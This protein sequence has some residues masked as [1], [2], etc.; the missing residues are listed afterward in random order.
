MAKLKSGTRVYGDATVDSK[1]IVTNGNVGVGTTNPFDGAVGNNGLD[2][3]RSSA[4]IF[5]RN[6]DTTGE[7][8]IWAVDQDWFSGPSYKGVGIRN[9]GTA[10]TGNV[11][12]SIAYAGGGSLVFQNTNY[13]LIY[14]NGGSPLIFGT[15]STERI[16]ITS[17]G[18]TGINT[19]NPQKILEVVTP[20]SDFASIGVAALA[21][22]GWTGIHFGY[23]ENNAD[24][25][26]SA[27]VFERIDGSARGKIHILNNDGASTASATLTDSRLTIQS[28][29][30]IGVGTQSPTQK[31][32]V[33]GNL[34]VVGNLTVTG[35]YPG[36][37]GGGGAFDTG[38]AVAI[39]MIF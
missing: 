3:N 25:R 28:N 23:R 19:N 11:F 32:H 27:I 9:F 7:S 14:T 22:N 31:L 10:T 17:S 6:K 15:L 8:S 18:N 4:I 13:G 35:T 16:R 1:L 21:L 24:Y 5:S 38:K 33:Q 26:K 29:G 39:S 12:G 2:V 34:H 20:A 30:N 36:G 37:G